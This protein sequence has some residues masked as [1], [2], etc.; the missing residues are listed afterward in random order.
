MGDKISDHENLGVAFACMQRESSLY[1]CR[2][3]RINVLL[4]QHACALPHLIFPP[5][6]EIHDKGTVICISL[7]LDIT[8]VIFEGGG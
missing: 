7:Q 4:D 6:W 1:C 3:E 2:S 8:T 5:P